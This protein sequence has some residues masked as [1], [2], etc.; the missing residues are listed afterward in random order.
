MAV[1]H[2]MVR[3]DAILVAFA[4]WATGCS[5]SEPASVT[6]APGPVPDASP[7]TVAAQVDAA[8]EAPARGVGLR[9]GFAFTV[10]QMGELEPCG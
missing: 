5:R 2:A 3:R 9:V 4:L 7:A 10:N 6:A 1:S 8:T